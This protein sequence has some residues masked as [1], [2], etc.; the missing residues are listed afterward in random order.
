L[1]AEVLEVL[2]FPNQHRVS[3][4][5]IGRG[6]VESSLHAQ[7]P[8]LFRGRLQTLAQ[9]LLTNQ[10]GQTLLQINNLLIDRCCGQAPIV[11]ML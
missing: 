11:A 5:Q 10:F 4:V 7:R 2:H 1:M 6:R 8:A 9:I 3:E